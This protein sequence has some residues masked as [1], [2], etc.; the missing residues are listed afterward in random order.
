MISK[1]DIS[2]KSILEEKKAVFELK[3]AATKKEIYSRG[4]ELLQNSDI[5]D[6][7]IKVG[8]M[9]TN[10]KLKNALGDTVELKDYLKKGKVVLTWYRGGWC[11]YCNFTLNYLQREL[12]SFKENGAYLIALTPELP[13]NSV[14]TKEKN[15]LQFEVLSDIGNKVARDYGIVFTLTDD[16]ANVY[17]T[18]FGMN[19]YNGDLSNELPLAATYIIDQDGIISYAFLDTDYRNRAEPSE[20]I[21]FLEKN[22]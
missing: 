5:I 13:D 3:A 15:N 9:A 18:S 16:V 4:I 21:T 17:N 6:K 11:P 7:A 12:T 14:S 8:D 1:E 20:L 22:K 19:L 2:L 10:F